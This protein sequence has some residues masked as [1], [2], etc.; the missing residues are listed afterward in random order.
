MLLKNK[1]W[2][3][4]LVIGLTLM[5]PSTSFAAT[6][7]NTIKIDPSKAIAVDGGKIT[8]TLS[9]DKQVAIYKGI[10]Y[11]APPVGD[12]RWKDPQPVKAWSGVKKA[13]KFSAN[14][15]QIPADRTQ[16]WMAVYTDEFLTDD[17][18]GYSE[19]CL[20][21]NVWTNASST[22]K[23]RPVIVYLH[24]GGFGSGSGSISTYDGTSLAKQDVVYVS[25]N[26]RLGIFGFL[27]DSK[28]AA[29]SK[30]GLTGNYGFLDQIAALKWVQKNIDK[31]GGDPSNVTIV[32]Q[33]AGGVSVQLLTISPYA[34]GLFKNAFC[35]SGNSLG[36]P[37]NSSTTMESQ[38]K[39]SAELFKGKTLEEMRAIPASELLKLQYVSRPCVD[40]KIIPGE[41]P[42]VLKKGTQNNVNYM[43][44]MV[45]GDA[46]LGQ[47]VSGTKLSKDDFT[48]IVKENFGTFA[49][50][51]LESYPVI[52]DDALSQ[53]KQLI[54]DKLMVNQNYFAKMM[55]LKSNSATYIY[56]FDHALPGKADFGAFHT[57]DV[58]Y[59]LNV[60]AP[61]RSAYL[62]QVDYNL[63]KTTSAYLVNFAKTGNPN[64]K[65]LPKWNAY[66]GSISNLYISGNSIVNEGLDHKKVKFWQDY[67]DSIYGLK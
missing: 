54:A 44:G 2:L 9:S 51:C 7:N 29:E 17:S 43:S 45:S 63:A 33:S 52:G 25:I 37:T 18:L 1:R 23:K 32:G 49:Q 15:M 30:D 67:S 56:Y 20:Y 5:V 55:A 59:W 19:D 8:G 24:G 27:G 57:G 58:P 34:K 65:G 35:M 64:G 42:N 50:E 3:A 41:V 38:E 61:N 60:F 39:A 36:G 12:L 16:P 4:S 47:N 22:V 13:T 40:G 10:P 6:S 48:K 14:A 21:L 31:F 62:K 53:Y 66:N 46:M 26:Y 11:A 28:L